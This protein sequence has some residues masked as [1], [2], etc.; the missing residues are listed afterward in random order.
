[1]LLSAD[2]R[3]EKRI[4]IAEQVAAA[5][6]QVSAGVADLKR[7]AHSSDGSI[8]TGSIN[9]NFESTSHPSISIASQVATAYLQVDTGTRMFDQYKDT[10]TSSHGR[11]EISLLSLHKLAYDLGHYLSLN[12]IAQ[13]LSTFAI[14]VTPSSSSSSSSSSEGG[15][16]IRYPDYI[17][18]WS[19]MEQIRY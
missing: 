11:H 6:R 5:Y 16:T 4:S 9:V 12:D 8:S 10:T 2:S 15:S 18:W 1:M 13:S 17:T 19:R 7:R 14:H 3:S